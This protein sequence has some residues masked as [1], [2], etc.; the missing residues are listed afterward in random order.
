M[1]PANN[2]SPKDRKSF[3]SHKCSA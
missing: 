1:K 2:V 3:L